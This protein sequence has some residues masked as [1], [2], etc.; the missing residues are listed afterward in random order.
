MS[1]LEDVRT[2]SRASP[3]TC[4]KIKYSNR[5]DTSGSCPPADHGWSATQPDFWH[6]AGASLLVD[7]GTL[8]VLDA[9]QAE[10]PWPTALEKPPGGGLQADSAG[11][12]VLQHWCPAA[13]L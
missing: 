6:P 7:V 5:S 13:S 3:S 12:P 4:Q 10:L 11:I 9:G 8:L 2:A 1:L